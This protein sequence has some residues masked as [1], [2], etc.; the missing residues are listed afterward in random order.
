[1]PFVAG[2]AIP[3]ENSSSRAPSPSLD[4]EKLEGTGFAFPLGLAQ[5]IGSALLSLGKSA[6]TA[7]GVEALGVGSVFPAA[8]S[9]AKVLPA[10]AIKYLRPAG[11]ATLE[12]FPGNLPSYI[13]DPEVRQIAISSLTRTSQNP[14]TAERL[15]YQL[16]Q[17]RQ[18]QVQPITL[19]QTPSGLL[20]V[21]DGMHRVLAAER[22][23]FTHIPAITV[24][25]K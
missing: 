18:G 21:A 25:A 12:R 7:P 8:T 23:G 1:M 9:I 2:Q 16:K 20:E 14:I 22:L 13:V 11:T 24:R 4:V 6:I 5:R 15:A 10:Q 19:E 3:Y 17:V